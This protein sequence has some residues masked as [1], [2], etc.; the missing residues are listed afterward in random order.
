M[1]VRTN[2]VTLCWWAA[3]VASVRDPN[4]PRREPGEFREHPAGE[5]PPPRRELEMLDLAVPTHMTVSEQESRDER[6][7][8]TVKCRRP[9]RT[10]PVTRESFILVVTLRTLTASGEFVA[11]LCL[12]LTAGSGGHW[13]ISI[14]ISSVPSSVRISS[15]SG[16]P[17]LD[18]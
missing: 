10:L 7:L 17:L 1:G 9:A 12:F 6:A 13:W 14:V 16:S 11:S 15:A 5:R 2:D 18:G 4:H 8:A 3:F